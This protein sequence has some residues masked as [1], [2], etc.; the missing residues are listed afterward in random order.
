MT[1]LTSDAQQLPAAPTGQETTALPRFGNHPAEHFAADPNRGQPLLASAF[2]AVK[3]LARGFQQRSAA[4]EV[5]YNSMQSRG[6]SPTARQE[7]MPPGYHRGALSTPF[8]TMPCASF[9]PPPKASVGSC[10]NPPEQPTMTSHDNDDVHSASPA[11]APAPD[12]F[13]SLS[14]AAWP[15]M[16]PMPTLP[17]PPSPPPGLSGALPKSFNLPA[18]LPKSFCPPGRQPSIQPEAAVSR[19][20]SPNVVSNVPAVVPKDVRHFGPAESSSRP[21]PAD[22]S[23]VSPQAILASSVSPPQAILA[24]QSAEQQGGGLNHQQLQST[25]EQNGD[26]TLQGSPKESVPAAVAAKPD[27]FTDQLW[28]STFTMLAKMKRVG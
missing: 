25:S 6:R 1:T 11:P 10:L 12:N 9:A 18:S 7:S 23:T 14:S 22:S 8:S 21:V 16:A 15:S 5:G 2:N 13:V 26:L 24:H 27:G 28:L 17:M 20:K 19:P 4:S 3:S